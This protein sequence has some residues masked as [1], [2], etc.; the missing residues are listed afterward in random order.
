MGRKI[1]GLIW[2]GYKSKGLAALAWLT[3][4]D[5]KCETAKMSTRNIFI[6]AVPE[7]LFHMR[8]EPDLDGFL[9][10]NLTGTGF[11]ILLKCQGKEDNQTTVEH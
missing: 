3:G 2:V 11:L 9:S 5:A 7:L 8:P 6:M 1:L 4:P 10:V